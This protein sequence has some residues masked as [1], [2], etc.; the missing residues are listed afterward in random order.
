[1]TR[2]LQYTADA[3]STGSLYALFA[4]G[5]ALVLSVAGIANFAYGD[6]MMVAAYVLLVTH[7]VPWPLVVL[8]V[9]L[10]GTGLSVIIDRI[11]FRPLRRADSVSLLVTS[12]AVSILLE[13]VVEL[14]A[15]A[16]PQSINFGGSFN[17]AVSL[18]S[19]HVAR[20]DLLT[21]AV[22]AVVLGLLS[23]FLRRSMIG[24]QLRAASEDF[25]MARLAGVHA[26]RVIAAAFA[27][28]GATAGIAA[29]LLT[30]QSGSLSIDMGLQPTLIAFIAVVIGGMGSVTG[31][32]IGGLLLGIVSVVLQATLPG[33]L[34]PYHDAIL[35]GAV[36]FVLLARPQGLFGGRVVR[37]RV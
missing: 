2:V 37:E 5:L 19:V 34:L 30:I 25:A 32:T 36:I 10:A 1:M 9:I 4:C 18:G 14:I 28:S 11:A 12:F 16:T 27:I 35:F 29:T 26:N 24:M 20:L 3:L 17:R 13:N 21:V 33:N 8:I 22:T 31:A 6:V 23:L 7:S 15:G